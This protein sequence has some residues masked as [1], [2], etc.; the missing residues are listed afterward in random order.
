M[1]DENR[2]ID[3]VDFSIG[4]CSGTIVQSFGIAGYALCGG[5]SVWGAMMVCTA[6][7]IV[8]RAIDVYANRAQRPATDQSQAEPP[9]TADPS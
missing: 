8:A 4:Y 1:D 7:L 3:K 5:R 9:P 6:S 2:P